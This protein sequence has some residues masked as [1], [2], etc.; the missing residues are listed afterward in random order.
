MFIVVVRSYLAKNGRHHHREITTHLMS[1]KA[2]RQRSL[3]Y[4][5]SER[6]LAG[7]TAA[8]AVVAAAVRDHMP[9]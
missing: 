8:A 7:A 6:D 3:D 4:S 1:V 5:A 2:S 9:A